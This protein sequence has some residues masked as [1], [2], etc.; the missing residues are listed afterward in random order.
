M[1]I[2]YLN[3]DAS[4]R[5]PLE[6]VQTKVVISHPDSIIYSLEEFITAFNNEGISDLGYIALIKNLNMEKMLVN[7]KQKGETNGTV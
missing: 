6:A 3:P 7:K 1:K 5:L 4:S 2:A